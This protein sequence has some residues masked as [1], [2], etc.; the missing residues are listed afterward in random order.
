VP[1]V[2]ACRTV[3]APLGVILKTVP[4]PQRPPIEVVCAASTTF[5]GRVAS[6]E[7]VTSV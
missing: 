3:T 6:T 4:A 1:P 5:A 2:N 7:N